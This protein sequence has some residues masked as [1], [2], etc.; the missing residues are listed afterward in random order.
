MTV[1]V[2]RYEPVRRAEEELP[3]IEPAEEVDEVEFDPVTGELGVDDVED[4]ETP[5]PGVD[6]TM[7]TVMLIVPV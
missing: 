2:V 1:T 6:D 4:S 7:L 5:V 3:E